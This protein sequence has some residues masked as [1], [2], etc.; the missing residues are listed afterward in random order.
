MGGIVA[1]HA[2]TRMGEASV[3]AIITMSTP[4]LIPPVTFE[5]GMQDIYDEI[6]V[7]WRDTHLDKSTAASDTPYSVP[8]V[9]ISICGGTADTQISSDSCALR[10]IPGIRGSGKADD[11]DTFDNGTFAVF[12]TGMEG[13]WTGVDHQAM[14]WCD[15]VRR[16]VATTLLDMSATM[17]DRPADS[18]RL[19][20]ELA[21]SARRRLLGERTKVELQGRREGLSRVATLKHHPLTPEHPTFRHD[22]T[23]HSVFEVKVPLNATRFQV[24]GSMRLNGVGRKGGSAMSIHLEPAGNNSPAQD[25]LIPLSTLR[26]LP[27][28]VG[29]AEKAAQRERFPVQGEGVKDEEVL[30]YAEA[31]FEAANHARNI[32]LQLEGAGWGSVSLLGSDNKTCECTRVEKVERY[33]RCVSPCLP[34]PDGSPSNSRIRLHTLTET[35]CSC[36]ICNYVGLQV[37]LVS[38]QPSR[39][40]Q[41]IH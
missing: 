23:G 16:V 36:M 27:K 6:D 35:R 9:L 25:T 14:V 37:V 22:G 18:V 26:I 29:Q 24:I 4:H 30:T 17:Y 33:S 38:R 13:V 41:H 20:R 3:P 31:D 8:P 28:S 7:F 5:R 1:R 32:V 12:T 10:P 39:L 40:P 34:Q 15:Q 21:H 11:T 2:V 19:R